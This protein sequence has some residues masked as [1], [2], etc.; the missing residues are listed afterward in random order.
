MRI[1]EHP[2]LDFEKKRK[3]KV[4]IY[5]KGQPI[6]AYEGETIAAALHAAGI[7]VL[8]YSRLERGQ[9]DYSALS[10]SAPHA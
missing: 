2:I 8:N 6:E 5:Y 9:E 7:R 3:R 1:N 4:T 10:G